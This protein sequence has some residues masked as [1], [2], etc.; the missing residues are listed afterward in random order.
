MKDAKDLGLCRR[1]RNSWKCWKEKRTE[2]LKQTTYLDEEMLKK[3]K[4]STLK[5]RTCSCCLG[6][7]WLRCLSSLRLARPLNQSEGSPDA[8]SLCRQQAGTGRVRGLPP[9]ACSKCHSFTQWADFLPGLENKRLPK[10]SEPKRGCISSWQQDLKIC[11][12]LIMK[13]HYSRSANWEQIEN[14]K[15]SGN[16]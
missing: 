11:S 12:K 2:Q 8:G 16:Q 9:T 6:L 7:S 15:I 10:G 5:S 4:D 13:R 1:I 14:L 3:E